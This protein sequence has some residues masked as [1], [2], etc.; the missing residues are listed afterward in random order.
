[1]PAVG[2]LRSRMMALADEKVEQHESLYQLL[3]HRLSKAEEQGVLREQLEMMS[4]GEHL[5]TAAL[6]QPLQGL[7][8]H[9]LRTFLDAAP[10]DFD[11]RGASIGNLILTGG[12]LHDRRNLTPITLLLNELLD[13]RGIVAPI[14]QGVAQLRV[15]TESGRQIVGQHLM[16]GKEVAALNE[17][18][19]KVELAHP[20]GSLIRLRHA[21]RDLIRSAQL[22]VFPPGS[23]FSS[24]IANLLPQGV[25]QA[26]M[27]SS[28]PKVF[29]PNLGRDP[30]LEGLDLRQQIEALEAYI[31]AED[32]VGE[33]AIDAVLTDSTLHARIDADLCDWLKSRNIRLID[34][35]LAASDRSDRY[36][37][38]KLSQALLQLV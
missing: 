30:E 2:D 34:T 14:T 38:Q 3:T 15:F 25:G 9:Y 5:L 24:V 12:Y 31:C 32:A 28:A 33:S 27:D 21:E 13:I 6:G 23:F 7:L 22:I 35:D 4:R 20:V 10:S 16:T 17:R 19:T 11:Y 1:M 36:D 37:D 26:V 29:I 8:C 18:I